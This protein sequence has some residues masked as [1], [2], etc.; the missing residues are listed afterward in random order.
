MSRKEKHEK[1]EEKIENQRKMSRELLKNPQTTSED[2][3]EAASESKSFVE[4][5]EESLAKLRLSRG[6]SLRSA[7]RV[8]ERADEETKKDELQWKKRKKVRWRS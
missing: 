2:E 5:E 4:S 8:C 1:K 6:R 7:E 3:S